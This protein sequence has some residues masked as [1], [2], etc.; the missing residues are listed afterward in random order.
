MGKTIIYIV[1]FGILGFGVYHFFFKNAENLYAEKEASFTFRDT[2]SIGKIFLVDNEG[3]SI[4]LERKSGNNWTL[5][6]Q[7]QAMPIQIVN[8]LTCLKLQTALKPVADYEHDRVVKL[9]AGMSTKVEVYNLKNEKIGSFFVAGQGPNYHGS[10]MIQEGASKAYLV[11]IPGFDGYLTPR[12]T[13]D[14]YDWRSRAMINLPMDS[15]YKI[16]LQY[17]QPSTLKESFVIT[18]GKGVPILSLNEH[19]KPN[20]DSLNVR[21]VLTYLGLFKDINAEGILNGTQGLDSLFHTASLKC[22]LEVQSASL[23]QKIYDIY[24]LPAKSAASIEVE[25][26]LQDVERMYAIDVLH[27]D[28]LLIQNRTFDKL[29]RQAS[30]FYHQ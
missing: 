15:I 5:N 27:K 9:L 25:G 13:V 20:K 19:Y 1:L 14:I 7:Y 30:D 26:V 2:A 6:K 22:R 23:Q 17:R 3:Q 28:T 11:E 8:I 4:L 12:Y 10:Y 16:D 21:R 29:L 24:W 18:N